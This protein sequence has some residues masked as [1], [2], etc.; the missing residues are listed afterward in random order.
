[1]PPTKHFAAKRD[2]AD[3]PVVS[4]SIDF[5][6]NGVREPHEFKA[7]PRTSYGDMI[8]IVK[9][10]DDDPGASLRF[11]DRMI[12][13]LL[14]DSDGTPEQWTAEIKT[15]ASPAGK[16]TKADAAPVEYFIDPAGKRQPASDLPKY[17][18][19]EAGSSRRRWAYLLQKDDDVEVEIDQVTDL[20]EWLASEAADR[21]TS[22]RSR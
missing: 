17:L 1:M 10:Q 13:R 22:K 18:A 20:F 14:V 11:L 9:N 16:T 4:F 3:A 8:G 6:R 12:R 19:F 15:E 7:V 5:V 2:V 21:P